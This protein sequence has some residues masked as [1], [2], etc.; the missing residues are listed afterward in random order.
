[1]RR[2]VEWDEWVDTIGREIE[3]LDDRG[4]PL[5]V[6]AEGGPLTTDLFSNVLADLERRGVSVGSLIALTSP[7][8]VAGLLHRTDFAGRTPASVEEVELPRDVSLFDISLRSDGGFPRRTLVLF[9]P[10]IVSLSGVATMPSHVALVE[11][12]S[13]PDLDDAE[14]SVQ[15]V[16]ENLFP[17]LYPEGQD[18]ET[19]AADDADGGDTEENEDTDGGVDAED[20][21]PLRRGQRFVDTSTYTD[22]DDEES[23][24]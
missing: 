13:V 15:E 16:R 19:T 22:E 20:D 5:R 17:D 9:R 14:I 7:T 8:Q 4:R 12:L 6:D 18:A 2:P 10:D 24:D 11:N 3:P 21:G 23:H 1:M